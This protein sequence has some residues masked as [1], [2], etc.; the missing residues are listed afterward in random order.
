MINLHPR[1][2]LFAHFTESLVDILNVWLYI[3]YKNYILLDLVSNRAQTSLIFD[4]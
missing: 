4:L 3:L 1:L 2:E